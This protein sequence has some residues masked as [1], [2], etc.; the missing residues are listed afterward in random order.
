[1]LGGCERETELPIPR[2][3]QKLVVNSILAA[4]HPPEVYVGLSNYTLDTPSAEMT[5]ATVL[6]QSEQ[7]HIDTLKYYQNGIYS[8][9]NLTVLENRDYSLIVDVINFKQI[10][11]TEKV[12]S[13]VHFT[14]YTFEKDAGIGR[15][16][17]QNKR[18]TVH[19]SDKAKEKNFYRLMLEWHTLDSTEFG[20]YVGD[21]DWYTYSPVIIAEGNE[22]KEVFSDIL[23]N[24]DSVSI[25][26]NFNTW[27]YD[28]FRDLNFQ[29]KVYLITLSES[30]YQFHKSI[31][32]QEET[33]DNI[34]L[35]SSPPRLYSNIDG[36]L[37]IF[38]AVNV[39]DSIIINF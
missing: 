5:K 32:Q 2:P 13:A 6:L 36:A 4:N 33:M 27:D 30:Y 38:S 20:H 11:Q 37:G 12:P 26:M 14:D 35:S 9:S 1:M 8:D 28:M 29:V 16:G 34:W 10:E 24:G 25:A 31:E 23:F 17:F 7:S 22:D 3:K 15:D 19:F 21:N 18:I 39:S